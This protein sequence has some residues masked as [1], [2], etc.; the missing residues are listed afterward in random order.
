MKTWVDVRLAIMI[1]RDNLSSIRFAWGSFVTWSN[2]AVLKICG[3]VSLG[4]KSSALGQGSL[5]A[6]VNTGNHH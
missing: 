1:A 5:E 2:V 6:S 4:Q 3:Q